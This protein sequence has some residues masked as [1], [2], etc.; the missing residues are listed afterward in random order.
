MIVK[1]QERLSMLSEDI[2]GLF[3]NTY[4]HS[5]KLHYLAD[6]CGERASL[7]MSDRLNARW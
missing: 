6:L 2:L 5:Y 3:G 7:G 4:I 1:S